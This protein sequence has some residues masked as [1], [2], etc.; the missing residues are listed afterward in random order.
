MTYIILGSDLIECSALS[1]TYFFEVRRG[2]TRGLFKLGRKVG[3]AAIV[4]LKGNF[5][6]GHLPV[7]KQFLGLFNTLLNKIVLDG[8]PFH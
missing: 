4:E 5:G 6:E 3:R 8:P 2:E 1:H 7:D